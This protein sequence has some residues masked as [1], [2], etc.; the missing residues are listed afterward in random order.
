M[1]FKGVRKMKLLTALIIV[2]GTISSAQSFADYDAKNASSCIVV[3]QKHSAGKD[4]PSH[5]EMMCDGYQLTYQVTA[6]VSQLGDASYLEAA[7]AAELKTRMAADKETV[8]KSGDTAAI[9]YTNC[10]RSSRFGK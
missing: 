3:L 2:T 10:Y 5:F 7:L 9:W 8:C 4:Q 1:V 6:D